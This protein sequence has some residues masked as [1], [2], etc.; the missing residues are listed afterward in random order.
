MHATLHAAD[1]GVETGGHHGPGQS[2]PP[3]NPPEPAPSTGYKVAIIGGGPAG[4]SIAWQL[5]LKGHQPVVFDRGE[6]LGGKITS[7]IPSLRIPDEIVRHE[8]DRVKG[9]IPKVHLKKE[10]AED[11]FTKLRDE[12][13]YVVIADG[14]PETAH[15]PDPRDRKGLLRPRLPAVQ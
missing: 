14:G 13:D 2:E 5:Y 9:L 15:A 11:E 10:M 8:I 3:G 4:L 1:R 12:Y 7:S 6:E